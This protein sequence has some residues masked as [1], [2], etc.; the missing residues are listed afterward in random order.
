MTA[1]MITAVR[2]WAP[3][4]ASKRQLSRLLSHRAASAIVTTPIAAPASVFAAS[5]RP[6]W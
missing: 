1:T 5:D 4:N 3:L 2:A 6:P